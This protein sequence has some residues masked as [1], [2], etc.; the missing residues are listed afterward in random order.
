M[1]V[2]YYKEPIFQGT[3]HG[4]YEDGK[5]V[6]Y[7]CLL[8]AEHKRLKVGIH[9][10]THCGFILSLSCYTWSKRRRRIATKLEEKVRKRK[11]YE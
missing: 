1:R 9:Q 5:L 11:K 7:K 8:V 10:C 2:K 3:R 6:Y 4:H